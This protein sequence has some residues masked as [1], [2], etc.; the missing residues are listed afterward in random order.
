MIGTQSGLSHV[1]DTFGVPILYT[2]WVCWG[3]PPW[4]GNNVYLPKLLWDK[5]R[6]RPLT[7]AEIM[8]AKLGC[9]ESADVFD[10]RRIEPRANTPEDIEAGVLQMLHEARSPLTTNL[11]TKKFAELDVIFNGSVGTAYLQ[12]HEELFR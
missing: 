11:A 4:Y 1:A 6:Q 10:A 8:Q 9:C 12:K 7:F 5:G 3:T 2:N